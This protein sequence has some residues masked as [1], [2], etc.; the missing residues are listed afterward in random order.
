MC[1]GLTRCRIDGF[2]ARGT[3]FARAGQA[4]DFRILA[5]T[6][7]ARYG[8]CV[9]IYIYIYIYIYMYMCVCIYVYAYTDY[10]YIDR[11]IDQHLSTN[12]EGGS[13]CTC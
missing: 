1:I 2:S 9:Y 13:F 7:P 11:N 5:V 3:I 10:I 4:P 8:V 12:D 6:T